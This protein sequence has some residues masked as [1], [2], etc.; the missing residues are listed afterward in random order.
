MENYSKLDSVA[1]NYSLGEK[2]K[3]FKDILSNDINKNKKKWNLQDLELAKKY[4]VITSI[5]SNPYINLWEEYLAIYPKEN[6][7]TEALKVG[8]E[9]ISNSDFHTAIY[10]CNTYLDK[11]TSKKAAEKVQDWSKILEQKYPS[12]ENRKEIATL[13]VKI[14]KLLK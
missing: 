2:Q 9:M 12:S 5:S 8:Y 14:D 7:E 4:S 11:M 3:I 10:V 1:K 6:N 13:K